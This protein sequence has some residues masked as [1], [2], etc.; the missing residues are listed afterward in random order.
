M[1]VGMRGEVHQGAILTTVYQRHKDR[2]GVF[3]TKE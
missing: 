1:K 3:T 2:R